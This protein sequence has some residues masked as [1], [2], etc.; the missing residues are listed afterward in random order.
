MSLKLEDYTV[1]WVCALPTKQVAT[2][3]MLDERRVDLPRRLGDDN[4]YSLGSIGNHNVAIACDLSHTRGKTA[5]MIAA[6]HG[7]SR[8]LNLLNNSG[9]ALM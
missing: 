2:I 7:Y 5:V 3:A 8:V 9:E 1:G 6:E 4:T